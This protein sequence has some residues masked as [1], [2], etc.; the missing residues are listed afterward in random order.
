MIAARSRIVRRIH[1]V[2]VSSNEAMLLTRG[3]VSSAPFNAICRFA[4]FRNERSPF[5]SEGTLSFVGKIVR[6]LSYV[7]ICKQYQLDRK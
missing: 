6:S 1:F 3:R 5:I 7:S 4:G 2:L